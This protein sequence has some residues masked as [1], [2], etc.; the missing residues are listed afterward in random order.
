MFPFILIG[1]L[2]ALFF[3]LRK[4][5]KV[6]FF[7]PFYHTGGAEKVHAQ[8][9]RAAG[10]DDSIIYFTRRSKD[11]TFLEAF[12]QSGA[13]IK[14]IS[15]YTDRKWLYPVNIVYRGWIS[16][17][18]NRQRVNPVVFNGQCNFAYK[19]SPWLNKGVR[20]I[21]LIHSLN[22]FSYIRIPFLPFISTTVMIS[23]KR[24]ADHIA[25]YSRYKIPAFMNER[26]Q[27][28][29]N[30]IPLPP[31]STIYKP[32]QP[33]TVL[34][35]GRGSKEKRIHLVAA[36]A[37]ALA[38]TTK[39]IRFEILGDVSAYISTQTHPYITYHGTVTDGQFIDA[40]YRRAHILLITSS[41]EGFPMV[42]MEAMAHG[43]AIL[44]TPV[45]DIPY[46]VHNDVNG[47]LF[48]NTDN[49]EAIIREGIAHIL[50][51]DKDRRLLQKI[52]ESNTDYAK[53]N[54]DIAKFNASYQKLI[55]E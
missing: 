25:L 20:Q 31:D 4:T 1:R 55:S 27:Y 43:C 7:F 41:T 18:I 30:C 35:V 9:T 19:L 29:P 45:G 51:L 40:V 32:E 2:M 3:P 44:A 21:E 47:F 52:S 8:I 42:V 46:H 24:I 17:H 54:F 23:K 12:R 33:L 26:I 6:Y 38:E 36:I 22:S 10:G 48:S 5:Y 39:N 13:T 14:D 53:E 15:A 37:T 11:S 28:I 34:Y 49:E 16:G 50:Q